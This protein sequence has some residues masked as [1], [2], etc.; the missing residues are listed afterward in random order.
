MGRPR[1]IKADV[2]DGDAEVVEIKKEVET[3]KAKEEEV[4]ITNAVFVEDKVPAMM[5]EMIESVKPEKDKQRLPTPICDISELSESDKQTLIEKRVKE[6]ID[7]TQIPCIYA[8]VKFKE[9]GT[10]A[11]PPMY[12]L[13]EYDHRFVDE[14]WQ[15]YKLNVREPYVKDYLNLI[16]K[17]C[18]KPHKIYT[19]LV[20]LN[21]E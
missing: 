14:G 1:K 12:A 8:L 6:I 7:Q 19:R 18:G 9:P 20:V 17:V 13:V 5:V 3:I 2:M 11:I 15:F 4:K 21:Y 16:A 10:T